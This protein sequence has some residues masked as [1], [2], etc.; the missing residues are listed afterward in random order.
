MK[1][2]IS[3]VTLGL[4]MGMMPC[5]YAQD[6][7]T[8]SVRTPGITRRQHRQQHRIRQGVRSGELTRGEF[9]RLEK[10][11]A[12]IQEDKKEAKADGTVTKD[13]RKELRHEQNVASRRI[14]R[15]KHNNRDRN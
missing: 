4:F 9:R 14:Y 2:L 15:A 7:S 10:E 13:E 11:Q 5:T 6:S 12:E 1:R 3:L 8:G